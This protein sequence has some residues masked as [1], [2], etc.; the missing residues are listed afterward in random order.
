[1]GYC[2]QEET[3]LAARGRLHGTQQEENQALTSHVE[4][5]KG[6]ERKYYGKKDKG[7][8]SSP[9]PEQKKKDLSHIQ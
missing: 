6:K 8:R 3:R 9:I 2:T 4:K 7:E 1:M 5:G